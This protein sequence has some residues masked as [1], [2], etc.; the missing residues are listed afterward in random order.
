MRVL[1]LGDSVAKGPPGRAVAKRLRDEGHDVITI[2]FEGR[3]PRW[4]ASQPSTRRT[5]EQSDGVVFLFGTNEE[6]SSGIDSLLGWSSGKPSVWI[7][8]PRYSRSD[9][10][11]RSARLDDYLR[12]RLSTPGNVF[13]SSR[14]KTEPTDDGRAGDK[15]HFTPE[16]AEDWISRVWAALGRFHA[17]AGPLLPLLVI[18]AVV[19]AIWMSK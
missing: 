11:A 3:G 4:L 14:D 5:I 19:G 7:G 10:D 18:A 1:L 12:S 6:P 15:V 9:L 17:S 2:A 13:I 8:P 16:G